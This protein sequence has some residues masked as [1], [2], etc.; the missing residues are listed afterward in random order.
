MTSGGGD[1]SKVQRCA[2]TQ[3]DAAKGISGVLYEDYA[4]QRR[5]WIRNDVESAP[6]PHSTGMQMCCCGTRRIKVPFETRR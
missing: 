2:G 3:R 4:F 6:N 1:R 5:N